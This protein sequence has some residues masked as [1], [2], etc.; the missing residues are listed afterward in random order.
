MY[1]RPILAKT[2]TSDIRPDTRAKMPR[3]KLPLNHSYRSSSPRRSILSVL[4]KR[5]SARALI[6]LVVVSIIG[7][8][9][10]RCDPERFSPVI[11]QLYE[12]KWLSSFTP[13]LGSFYSAPKPASHPP[14]VHTSEPEQGPEG[15]TLRE[16][17]SESIALEKERFLKEIQYDKDYETR[18]MHAPV[19]STLDPSL[20]AY[21]NRLRWFVRDYL[22]ESPHR[23]HLDL[24]LD[25]LGQHIAPPLYKDEPIPKVVLSTHK[26]LK[27]LPDFFQNW[28]KR[29]KPEGWEVK[30]AD[31][32]VMQTWF[33]AWSE[34]SEGLKRIWDTFPKP[35]LKTDF[36]RYVAMLLNGGI[37]TDSDTQVSTRKRYNRKAKSMS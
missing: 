19:T 24:M 27:G 20:E 6:L 11:Y 31:D 21:V 25:R 10:V 29:L 22:R 3:D 26:D 37:Y 28:E 16:L 35:V 23:P 33:D 7:F 5:R 1:N 2:L 9:V 14:Q 32:D 4:P 34:G 12:H 8:F 15:A 13:R 36:L 30:V 17:V 18:H